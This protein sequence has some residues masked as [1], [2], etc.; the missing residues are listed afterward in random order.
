MNKIH[1]AIAAAA[2]LATGLANVAHAQFSLPSI[3][4][5]TTSAGAAPVADLSGQQD[6]LVRGYIAASK[7]VLYANAK[8]AEALGLKDEA[9]KVKA[10]A[11]SFKEGATKDSAEAANKAVAASTDLV[12]KK[13][14]T[15]PAMDAQSKSIYAQG[16]VLLAAGLTQYVGVGKD[17]SHM[18][19][20]IKGASPLQLPKLLSAVYVVTKFPEAMTS[21]SGAMQNAVSFAQSSGIPLPSDAGAAADAL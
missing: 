10:E 20:S 9:A 12:A 17:V 7:D 6:S 19:S 13:I 5:V 21:V 8:L 4:G 14:A 16:L 15:Q 2:F 1:T 3:P 18:S 11:D